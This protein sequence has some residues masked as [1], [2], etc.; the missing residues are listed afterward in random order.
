[1]SSV[2]LHIA[3]ALG[4]NI[5]AETNLKK[6]ADLLRVQWSSIRFSS[7]YRTKPIGF[8]NQA[9]FLNAVAVFESEMPPNEIH[10][11]LQSIE[12]KLKKQTPF[13]NGPRTIDLDLLLYGDEVIE[14]PMLLVP[15][16]RMH[17]RRFVLE[18]LMELIDQRKIHPDLKKSWRKLHSTTIDQ[19]IESM[20]LRL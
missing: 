20:N 11:V 2:P 12:A 9:D 18:P 8:E 17:E 14:T 19:H 16:P 5:D 1:M 4:S 10:E 15:H 6:A 13:P 7:V 3:I